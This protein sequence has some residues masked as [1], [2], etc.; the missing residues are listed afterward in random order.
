[1]HVYSLWFSL[2]SSHPI[3]LPSKMV[4]LPW[5]QGKMCLEKS[6]PKKWKRQKAELSSPTNPC[7]F[8][9]QRPLST[10]AGSGCYRAPWLGNKQTQ[11]AETSKDLY[12]FLTCP[13]SSTPSDPRMVIEFDHWP[14]FLMEGGGEVEGSRRIL[15]FSVR[16]LWKLRLL[17][18]TYVDLQM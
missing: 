6:A 17:F 18:E 11:G 4:W 7:I 15:S 10:E 13:H 12:L 9:M 8:P 14:L 1:M 5:E 16:V 3:L 2:L